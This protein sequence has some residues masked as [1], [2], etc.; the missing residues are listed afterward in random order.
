MTFHGELF[1][2]FAISRRLLTSKN[3]TRFRGFLLPATGS[4]TRGERL[5]QTAK[6]GNTVGVGQEALYSRRR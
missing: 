1:F 2:S 3:R 6:S 4:G 5:T